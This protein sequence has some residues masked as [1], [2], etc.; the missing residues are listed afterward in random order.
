MR[1]ELL[2][3]GR[4][5]SFV[6]FWGN[7]LA[8]Y[9]LI[10]GGI[11]RTYKEIRKIANSI[12]SLKGVILTHVDYDHIGGLLKIFNDEQIVSKFKGPVYVNTPDLI[13]TPKKE[14]K[15]GL[16]H[17]ENLRSLLKERK[18]DFY[19]ALF[20]PD[21]SNEIKIDGLTLKLLSP[22]KEILEKLVATWNAEL[23]KQNEKK[24]KVTE[25]K[26]SLRKKNF[27]SFDQ[28][29]E[30]DEGTKNWERDLI[31][32]SSIA[33]IAEHNNK[34]ILFLGDAHPDVLCNCLESMGY[35]HK[36]RLEI[37]IV[38]ISHHGSKN[39][40]TSRLLNLLRTNRYIISTNGA[41]PYYHPH[42][43]AIVRIA[44]FGKRKSVGDK[45]EIIFNYVQSELDWLLTP[46]ERRKYNIEF[47][48]Q[49][50][51]PL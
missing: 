40:T 22:N 50:S 9:I 15:V 23:I 14:S 6:L 33:F 28:I 21:L 19:A 47:K 35:S 8:N 34:S 29:V 12:N 24:E 51:I 25:S 17:G 38:K 1:L 3:A 49:K 42:R 7:D 2:S 11:P 36:D 31:N 18:V 48:H 26:V 30:Q 32:A 46:E 44:H 4:G 10:D 45:V 39:N 41:G 37:D 20:D 16:V 43:E 27:Q 5:D 13:L